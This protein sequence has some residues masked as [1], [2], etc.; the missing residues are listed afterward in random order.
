VVLSYTSCCY[1]YHSFGLGIDCPD[2]RQIIHLGP[3]NDIEDYIQQSGRTGCDDLPSMAL[4]LHGANLMRN[5]TKTMIEYC[6][7][8]NVCHRNLLFADFDSYNPNNTGCCQCC[9]VCA[10][11]CS[12][13]KCFFT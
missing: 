2:V 8:T 4:L 5:S 11:L 3:P 6:K 10:L 7:R 12:C 1:C 13:S 9:V